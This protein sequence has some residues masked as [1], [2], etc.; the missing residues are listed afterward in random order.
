[1]ISLRNDVDMFVRLFDK[2]EDTLIGSGLNAV[3]KR[4]LYIVVDGENYQ[5]VMNKNYDH[6]TGRL[7]LRFKV[8][9]VFAIWV[10]PNGNPPDAFFEMVCD[11]RE[12]VEDL[13]MFLKLTEGEVDV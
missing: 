11:D 4:V 1:M 10:T 9:D 2:G 7:I 13:I 6:D 5:M 8:K 3:V 12:L